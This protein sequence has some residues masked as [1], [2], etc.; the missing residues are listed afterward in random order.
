MNQS[1]TTTYNTRNAA[2]GNKT[3]CGHFIVHVHWFSGFI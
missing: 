1:L 2:W 3:L